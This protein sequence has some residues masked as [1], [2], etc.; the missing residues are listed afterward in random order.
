MYTILN[1]ILFIRL[2]KVTKHEQNKQINFNTNHFEAVYKV[3]IMFH[4][5]SLIKWILWLELDIIST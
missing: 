3:Y 1:K 5:L 4:Y 2:P